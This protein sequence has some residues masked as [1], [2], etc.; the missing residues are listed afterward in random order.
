MRLT[1]LFPPAKNS[2]RNLQL[3]RRYLSFVKS[4]YNHERF[5]FADEKPMK[6]INIFSKVRRNPFS[7]GVPD[8]TCN[9]NSKNRYNILAAVTVKTTAK[10]VSFI[11]IE[12]TSNS[13]TFLKFVEYLIDNCVLVRGDIFVVD[14][15]SIHM[16]GD[17]DSLQNMLF[18]KCGI[19]MVP[20]PPYTP[21]LNPCEFVF[22]TLV[23][24]MRS[25]NNRE[26][27]KNN[28]KFIQKVESELSNFVRNDVVK[29]Y[30]HTGYKRNVRYILVVT[31]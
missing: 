28:A 19:L 7:G 4:I 6:E 1:S 26:R 23:Q 12:E 11:V 14:N 25:K 9:A 24:R 15:C 31:M 29:E 8:H 10:P 17:N 3:T 22:Q 13:Y 16:S 2:F 27:S 5:V 21:E 30:I 18:F 20:L